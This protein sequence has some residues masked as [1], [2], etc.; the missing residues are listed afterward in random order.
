MVNLI[1]AI[2]I[3]I[4]ILFIIGIL[5]IPFHISL[6][7][8]RQNNINQGYLRIR[9]WKIK[10]I[11]RELIQPKKKEKK[12]KTPKRKFDVNKLLDIL[13]DMLPNLIPNFIKSLPY[14]INIMESS[15]RSISIERIALNFIFG[16]GEA[17]DTAMVG[18]FLYSVAAV[19]NVLPNTYFLVEPDL[20]NERLDGSL[21]VKLK[22]TLLRIVAA[23]LKAL[24]K[25]PVISLLW[26][27][28]KV[29]GLF[30]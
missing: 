2:I 13:P 3:L 12:E 20:K 4:I 18:G 29:R 24:T 6:E 30:V 17:A 15:L 1:A 22:L 11:D 14:F 21:N 10:I 25:R 23:S 19:I 26:E 16:L 27:L 7:L 5:V 8:F 9:W 28:R